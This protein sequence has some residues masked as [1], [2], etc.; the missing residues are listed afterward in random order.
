MYRQLDQGL[1]ARQ[2]GFGSG[3]DRSVRAQMRNG[4]VSYQ[5]QRKVTAGTAWDYSPFWPKAVTK[6][7]L[8]SLCWCSVINVSFTHQFVVLIICPAS[9][10][11]SMAAGPSKELHLS[12]R[13]SSDPRLPT[14][15]REIWK[16][17]L[18][19]CNNTIKQ[20]KPLVHNCSCYMMQ[21]L[22]NTEWTMNVRPVNM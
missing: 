10:R 16:K 20:I 17:R 8:Y 11:C 12:I 15:H 1:H 19:R 6:L 4:T 18:G 13:P 14:G 21:S 5:R 2:L 3:E 22:H 9:T 7:D